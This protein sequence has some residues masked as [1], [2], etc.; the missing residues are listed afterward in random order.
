[1]N[2]KR[3]QLVMASL[4]LAL[5]SAVYLTW[6]F[7]DPQNEL[8]VD[9]PVSESSE[10]GVAQLVNNAYVETNT[11]ETGAEE[12]AM[13][14]TKSKNETIS[15]ARMKRESARDDAIELL[16]QIIKDTAAEGAAKEDAIMKSS[17]IAECI[18][19]EA[20]IETLLSA[21]GFTETVAFISSEECNIVVS[22]K[23]EEADTL[24]IQEI[25]VEQTGF[26]ADNIKIIASK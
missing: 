7:S 8:P 26:T 2:F 20:N 1:M 14:V 9:S 25:V 5:G 6:H 23:L 15:Q 24:I 3:K 12:T 22:G 13:N 19:K 21:K 16:N 18:M 11:G 4:V 17:Y 10:L